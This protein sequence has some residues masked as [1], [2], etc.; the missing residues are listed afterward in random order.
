M[1]YGRDRFND[2][3]SS[4]AILLISFYNEVIPCNWIISPLTLS[5]T[6]VPLYMVKADRIVGFILTSLKLIYQRA[7]IMDEEINL[8][9][10]IK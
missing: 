5:F 2:H 10:L 4:V 1:E 7:I 8:K 6:I 3:L 9:L